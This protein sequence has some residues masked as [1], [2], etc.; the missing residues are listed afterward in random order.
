MLKADNLNEMGYER[1]LERTN[2]GTGLEG[3]YV[4]FFHGLK[5]FVVSSREC[6]PVVTPS[7]KVHERLSH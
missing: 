5:H 3:T 2:Y 7:L 6:N 4:H 1:K